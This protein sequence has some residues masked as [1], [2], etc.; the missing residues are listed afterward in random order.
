LK[1]DVNLLLPRQLGVDT[2]VVFE[3]LARIRWAAVQVQMACFD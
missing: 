2:N 1:I 3:Q